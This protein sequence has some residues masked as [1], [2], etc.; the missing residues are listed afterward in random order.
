MKLQPAEQRAEQAE[1]Q[2][3]FEMQYI[4]RCKKI[5]TL[6]FSSVRRGVQ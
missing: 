5:F 4:L 3:D 1:M 2:Q 6:V